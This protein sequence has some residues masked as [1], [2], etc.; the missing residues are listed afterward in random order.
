MGFGL[1]WDPSA[2]PC[3]QFLHFGVG[4]SNQGL[5][6]HCILKAHNLPGFT[7]SQLEKFRLRMNHTSGTS[8]PALDAIY[9]R[10]WT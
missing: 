5:S 10:L 1:A 3:F 4:L 8:I 7:S 6:Y 9:M 2:L